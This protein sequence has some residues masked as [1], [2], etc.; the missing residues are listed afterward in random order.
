MWTEYIDT[1]IGSLGAYAY[2]LIFLGLLVAGES[3]LLPAIYFALDGK[4]HMPYVILI[5]LVATAIADAFWYWVGLHMGNKFSKR[6]VKGRVQEK[7]EKLAVPFERHGARILLLSK[8][9]YGTRTAV[10]ILAGLKKMKLREYLAVNLFG[11]TIITLFI[12]FLA[13]SIG[14]TIESLTELLHGVEVAFL[15]LVVVLALAQAVFGA[16]I[17]KLW[18]R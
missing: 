16:Y 2:A 14:F 5:A 7:I 4:L 8:F 10:Q 11:I 15:I 13:Y 12:V 3:V 17:K 1:F 9:V 6:M 18:L